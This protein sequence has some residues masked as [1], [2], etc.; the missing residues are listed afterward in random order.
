MGEIYKFQSL[1]LGITEALT[2]LQHSLVIPDQKALLESMSGTLLSYRELMRDVIPIEKFVVLPDAVRY[3]PTLEVRNTSIITAH[4][5]NEETDQ[6]HE[7]II[8]PDKNELVGHLASGV[9]FSEHGAGSVEG[10]AYT[11]TRATEC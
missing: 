1:I 11:G 6:L 2:K 10:A 9:P 8:T 3:Y 7:G 5:I 4:L